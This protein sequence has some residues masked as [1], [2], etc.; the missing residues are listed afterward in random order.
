MRVLRVNSICGVKNQMYRLDQCIDFNKARKIE[1]NFFDINSLFWS[2]IFAPSNVKHTLEIAKTRLINDTSA[3]IKAVLQS[4]EEFYSMYLKAIKSIDFPQSPE[5]LFNCMETLEIIC[6]LHTKLFS[7]PYKLTISNGYI[8]SKYSALELADNCL[9][10]LCNPYLDFIYSEVIPEIQSYNPEILVLTGRPN[11]ASFAIAKIMREWKPNVFI[12]GAEH[13]S[14]YYSLKKIKELIITNTALFSIYHC[15]TLGDSY[16]SISKIKNVLSHPSEIH[17]DSVPNIIYSLDGGDTIHQTKIQY[18][19]KNSNYKS[20]APDKRFAMNIKAF[21]NNH[22]YW[23]KCT[24]CGINSKY[25]NKQNKTWDIE[26]LILRLK[27]IQNS[28]VENVWF[29]DEAIPVDI[30]CR[31][32]NE[33]INNNLHIK[34]HV[35]TRIEKEFADMGVVDLLWKAGLR[36]ILFGFESASTRI[37]SMVNKFNGNFNYLETAEKIVS[38]FSNKNVLVHFSSIVGF[39]TEIKS[40]MLETIDFLKYMIKTY[41]NFSY[42]INTFYLDIGSKMYRRWETFGIESLSYPCSPKYFLENSLDWNC[43]VAPGK[44]E[45]IRNEQ[46]KAMAYQYSWYPKGALISPSV[47]F[48]F[49]EHSRFALI[50]HKRNTKKKS[51]FDI[52]SQIVLAPFVS[53]SCVS[54]DSWMLYNLKNHNYITGGDVLNDIAKANN[55]NVRFCEI[56]NKYE[57]DREQVI[58]LLSQLSRMEFFA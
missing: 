18:R 52:Y 45:L 57:Y 28:G 11:I 54:K 20:L 1:N 14:D 40:E 9:L 17:I 50:N 25:T 41:K 22:C 35:R 43:M 53:F 48:S 32:A 51:K 8:H 5:N 6:L 55:K 58:D 38:S 33:I 49:W 34:W 47:F 46:E 23:N 29:I 42:N 26:S 15:I 44:Y 27:T 13:E 31:C 16:E 4:S 2:Q 24:F 36:H 39:P 12:V 3:K 30:L 37:L 21:P 10:P 56:I 7:T 19:I